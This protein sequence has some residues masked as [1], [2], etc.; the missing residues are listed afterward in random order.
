[1]SNSARS[2]CWCFTLNNYTADE[3]AAAR[4]LN[5]A[6]GVAYACFAPEIAESGTPHL[7]GYVRFTNARSLASVRREHPRAHWES[8]RGTDSVFL[9]LTLQLKLGFDFIFIF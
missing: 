8:S 4:S 2:R 7:Q 9:F 6:A 1:M 3:F 5:S